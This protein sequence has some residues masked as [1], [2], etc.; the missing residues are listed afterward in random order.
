MLV[1]GICLYSVYACTRC[2][3]VLGVCLYSVYAVLSVNSCSWHGEIERDDL[4]L[5]SAMMV[6]LW[7]RNREMGMKMRTMWRIRA[8]MRNQGYNLPD[9]VGKTLYLYD[10]RLDRNSYLPSSAKHISLWAEWLRQSRR[11]QS[12]LS[13]TPRW[14]ITPYPFS[15]PCIAFRITLRSVFHRFFSLCRSLI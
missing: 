12:E 11:A 9:W 2:I 7:M 5:C 1:L 14:R 4:T 15:I 8:D 3:L 6:E 13:E 10:Y